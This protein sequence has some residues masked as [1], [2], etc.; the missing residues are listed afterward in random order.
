MVQ[1]PEVVL[2]LIS[3]GGFPAKHLSYSSLKEYL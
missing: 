3:N 2:E 1:I